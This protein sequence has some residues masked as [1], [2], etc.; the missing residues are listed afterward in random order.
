M[1]GAAFVFAPR[2]R[3]GAAALVPARK[4]REIEIWVF[5]KT[6]NA[7]IVGLTWESK[8]ETA[9]N[10][11]FFSL[12]EER[13][14][15]ILNAG[16]RVFSQN[17]YKHSPMK[18]VADEAGISKALLFHYFRNKREFYLFLLDTGARTTV[19]Y[20]KTCGCYEQEDLFGAMYLGMKA[21]VA[22][23]RRCPDMTAFV[24]KAY[25][26]RDEEVRGEVQKL[27]RK[28]GGYRANAYLVNLAPEKFRPGLDLNMMYLDMFWAS[29][30]Y[31]WEQVQ[32][33]GAFDV[34]ELEKNFVRLLDFWKSIYLRE[35]EG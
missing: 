9:M 14:Q 2:G 20:L 17:S 30:G 7:C 4:I 11:K 21:K 16:F 34:D 10:E 31:L 35:G 26:E 27:I 13:R 5:P 28:Y 12:P 23:M 25:Y 19:E 33:G 24:L 22:V 1:L 3:N 32:Q 15:A 8:E 6:V 18:E 29:E